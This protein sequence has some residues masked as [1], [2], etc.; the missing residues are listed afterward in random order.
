MG[1]ALDGT[2]L[3]G[4]KRFSVPHGREV[5]QRGL[6]NNRTRVAR[7]KFVTDQSPHH[8]IQAEVGVG[9]LTHLSQSYHSFF[10]AVRRLVRQQY[11]DRLGVLSGALAHLSEA[12][13]GSLPNK[14]IGVIQVARHLVKEQKHRS[15][16]LKE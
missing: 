5:R 15:L 8:C 1:P 13:G 4:F 7:T 16:K 6:P 11:S 14:P 2:V 10:P 9:G 12:M 3:L